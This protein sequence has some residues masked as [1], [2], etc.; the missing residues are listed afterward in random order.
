[1]AGGLHTLAV[2]G[3]PR[4]FP[5]YVERAPLSAALANLLNAASE[6]SRGACFVDWIVGL[7]FA[8]LYVGVPLF[9]M[10]EV[11]ALIGPYGVNTLPLVLALAITRGGRLGEK[12]FGHG[13]KN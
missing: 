5:S 3:E 8:F 10:S 6:R 7:V 12:V 13:D 1:M 9:S 4:G 11:A 2:D